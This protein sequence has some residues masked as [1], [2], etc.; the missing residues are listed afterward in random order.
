MRLLASETGAAIRSPMALRRDFREF[1]F[2]GNVVDLAVAVVVGGAFG[3]IVTAL[4]EDLVMPFVGI[5]L[6]S[7]Q[8]REWIWSPVP[9]LHLKIGHFVGS[10]VDFVIIAFAIFLVLV[11]FVGSIKNVVDR[12]KAVVTRTCPECL[13]SIPTGAKRCRACTSPVAAM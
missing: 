11:K 12:P 1:V 3:K 2:R 10:V 8:W 6:P 4:V 5:V 13:E 7:G 9:N